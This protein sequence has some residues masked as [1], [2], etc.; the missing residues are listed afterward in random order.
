M[1]VLPGCM[2]EVVRDDPFLS[3]WTE[4]YEGFTVVV[5]LSCLGEKDGV[6]GM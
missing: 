6:G 5:G 3:G 2:V 4:M 1:S